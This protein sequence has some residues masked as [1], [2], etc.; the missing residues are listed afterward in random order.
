VDCVVRMRDLTHRFTVGF[1]KELDGGD[2]ESA[3]PGQPGSHTRRVRGGRHCGFG[4]DSS[5]DWG[6]RY[7]GALLRS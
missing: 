4:F 6:M 7:L 5:G 1:A 2:R 3:G